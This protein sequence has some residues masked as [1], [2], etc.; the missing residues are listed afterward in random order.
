M[1][2]NNM[3]WFFNVLLTT[4]LLLNNGMIRVDYYIINMPSG[5]IL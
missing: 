1:K 4:K 3:A 2:I 5:N